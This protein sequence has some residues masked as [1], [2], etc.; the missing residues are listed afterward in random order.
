MDIIKDKEAK[1]A[2]IGISLS[3]LSTIESAAAILD[4]DLHIITLEKMFSMSDVKYFLDNYAGKQNAAIAVSVPEN[5][6]MLSSKWKYN[7]RT[8]DLV[9][10]DKKMIN[11]ED[12]TNRF[13]TRGSEYFKDLRK[14]EL[15]IFRFDV[16]NMKQVFG[17]CCAYKERTP[18]DCKS[19]QDTLR[20][21]YNMRELPVNMLPV[22]QLEAILGAILMQMICTNNKDFEYK[23]IGE[24][25]DIPIIGI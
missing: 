1:I 17:K 15:D 16:E 7:S 22:A 5:E 23:Q 3:G 20:I 9:N 14:K 6:V 2:F 13:S 25:D 4:K 24:F 12:W 10:F 21:K 19:L 18:I 8:Y 11:R